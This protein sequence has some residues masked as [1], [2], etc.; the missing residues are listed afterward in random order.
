MRH[1]KH[2]DGEQLFPVPGC[3][4]TLSCVIGKTIANAFLSCEQRKVDKGDCISFFRQK[5]EVDFGLS[6]NHRIIKDIPA[7]VE[8]RAITYDKNLDKICFII[9]RDKDC[10]SVRSSA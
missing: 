5:Y 1:P 9:D 8:N 10:S 2:Q 6:M 4:P 7:I 3:Q